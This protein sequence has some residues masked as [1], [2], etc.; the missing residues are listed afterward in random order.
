ME[1]LVSE[2][3]RSEVCPK[4]DFHWKEGFTECPRCG[5]VVAK[6]RPEPPEAGFKAPTEDSQL[7][8]PLILLLTPRFRNPLILAGQTLLLLLMSLLT[9]S[10]L[11]SGIDDQGTGISLLH[12]VNLPFHEAG[13]IIFSPFG[14]LITSLGG[15]LGQL[16]VP[17]VC[18]GVFLR[19]NRDPFAAAVASWWFG[20]NL[21]DIAPYINDA[22]AGA[23]PLTGGNTGQS[24]PYGFHDWEYLLTESGLLH[25][26]AQ[27]AWSSYLLGMAVAATSLIWASFLI[28][29]GFRL[30]VSS[31]SHYAAYL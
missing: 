4:C 8:F 14:R 1:D 3:S 31:R 11:L 19:K 5:I 28:W 18:A 15:T 29:T 9:L 16:L 27:I 20:E 22:R 6:Y 12:M 13:H 7:S 2:L 10:F 23:L 26:D 21:I 30:F 17:I 24:A 25:L